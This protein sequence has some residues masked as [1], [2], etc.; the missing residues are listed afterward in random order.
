MTKCTETANRSFEN[1]AK[2]KYL[3]TTVTYQNLFHEEVQSKINS[4]NTCYHSV[5]NVLSSHLLSKEVII[6]IH[7]TTYNFACSFIWVWNLISDI[8]GGTRTDSVWGWGAKENMLWHVAP[9][10]DTNATIPR[11]Q[12]DTILWRAGWYTP[13]IR[14]V[15]IR[16]IGF[17]SS[18][19]THSRLI[20]LTYSSTALSLIYTIYRPPLHTH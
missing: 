14:R 18:W 19:V 20:T 6:K 12:E 9:P 5:Q 1:V 11:Q 16:M 4:I 10:T 7:K 13:L 3:G 15:L 8:I 2:F 17:I